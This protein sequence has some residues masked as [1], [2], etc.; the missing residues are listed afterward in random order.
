MNPIIIPLIRF[1]PI[2]DSV[3]NDTKRENINY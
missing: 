2:V 3:E 1:N